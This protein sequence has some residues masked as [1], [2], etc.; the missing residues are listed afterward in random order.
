MVTQN[1]SFLLFIKVKSH[2]NHFPSVQFHGKVYHQ[3]QIM[4][5]RST[6]DQ[7]HSVK[8]VFSLTVHYCNII[9]YN[10]IVKYEIHFVPPSPLSS[11]C[12]LPHYLQTVTLF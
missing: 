2:S 4:K 10:I 3:S 1:F 7:L 6:N 9:C 8:G 11:L 5:S 12:P